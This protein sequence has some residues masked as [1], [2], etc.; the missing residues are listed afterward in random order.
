MCINMGNKK[1]HL[2]AVQ[3]G[4]R[5]HVDVVLVKAQD[6]FLFVIRDSLVFRNAPHVFRNRIM[7]MGGALCFPI[8]QNY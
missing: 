5:A 7:F 2:C 4:S 1:G 8:N 3:V 6:E